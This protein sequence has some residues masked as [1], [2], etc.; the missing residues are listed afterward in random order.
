MVDIKHSSFKEHIFPFLLF[1]SLFDTA[2]I[3]LD[4][5]FLGLQFN[6]CF[7]HWGMFICIL[8]Y[9]SFFRKELFFEVI[10]NK[11]L[12]FLISLFLL[13]TLITNFIDN[14]YW[15]ISFKYWVKIY[16]FFFILVYIF[17]TSV[18]SKSTIIWFCIIVV[19]INFI[20][21]LEYLF[22]DTGH[23]DEFFCFFRTE[24]AL[25]GS[26]AVSSVFGNQNI[27]GSLNSIFL[28]M[29]LT[30]N[31]IHKIDINR[32][33]FLITGMFCLC[34]VFLSTSRNAILTLLIG[35]LLWFLF[36]KDKKIRFKWSIITLFIFLSAFFVTIKY[37]PYFANKYGNLKTVIS[38]IGSHEDVTL[39]DFTSIH[40]K[41]FESRLGIWKVA[42]SKIKERPLSG[43]GTVMS[44]WRLKDLTNHHHLHNLYIEV[45]YSSGVFGFVL[46]FS[47][48]M[49]WLY[50][51]RSPQY[52]A[53]V[54]ALM[55]MF[56]FETFI[57]VN[58][59]IVFIPWVAA[60]TT[61]DLTEGSDATMVYRPSE[62][63]FI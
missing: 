15:M 19:C 16:L 62:I 50:G 17:R 54:I 55:F 24:K 26:T 49:L 21:M 59:W 27:Y 1:F 33:Y 53:P 51:L 11:L 48:F 57:N 36:E 4:K 63:N 43:W 18:V 41:S 12:C 5:T 23:M 40:I 30:L 22:F 58:T 10:R 37:D 6:I 61:V 34:G 20:A 8:T 46:L 9:I 7:G 32:Y 3:F 47:L 52:L 35:A 42:I 29:L 14:P 45:L 13:V 31:S 28:V 2:K 56:M 39:D 38:K 60:V 25:K 44:Y